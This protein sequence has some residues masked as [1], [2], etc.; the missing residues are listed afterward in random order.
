MTAGIL[1]L[2][3]FG[4][5]FVGWCIRRLHVIGEHFD[6][7]L[8]SFVTNV[9]LPCLIVNS[10]QMDFSWQELINCAWLLLLALLYLAV[11]FGVGFGVGRLYP[12]DHR[13]RITHYS[14]VFT[15]FTFMGVPVVE[16]LFGQAALFHFMIFL[17]PL[18]VALYVLS[19]PI[20][21]PPGVKAEKRSR[22]GWI[23]PPLA[24]VPVG[25]LLYV[26]G[27]Q[28][29]A[30]PNQI[31]KWIASVCSPLGMLLCGI[32]LAKFPLKTLLRPRCFLMALLR[33]FLMPGIFLALSLLFGI[34]KELAEPLVITAALPIGALMVS[35]TIKYDDEPEAHFD[36]AGCVLIS[37]LLSA[38]A[39]PVWARLL[40]L[41]I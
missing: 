6:K 40:E 20:L 25:L 24:A 23:T 26:T 10:M 2:E 7:D 28:L 19:R 33:N 31:L 1:V 39:I 16:T 34:S 29:P 36:A 27:W 38:A 35:F 3:L 22:F 11:S 14:A 12:N 13:R 21:T 18:R 15:N 5:I 30:I 32:T 4:M 41:L 8:A 9:S 37:T 17:V